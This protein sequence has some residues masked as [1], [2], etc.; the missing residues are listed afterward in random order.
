MLFRSDRGIVLAGLSAGAICWFHYG[1]SD[2]RKFSAD[3]DKLIKVTGLNFVDILLC[4]HYD[5][6][7]ARQRTLPR[8]V[9]S[10][11][12]VAVALDNCAALEIVDD[13][14]RIILSKPTAR[15][16]KAYW[17]GGEYTIQ[18]LPPT[19]TFLRL[20]SLMSK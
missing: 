5:T 18:A 19:D 2:S 14:Y 17:E 4:P 9:R 13:S 8:M 1:S 3:T 20:S 6:E 11:P 12:Y 15:A 10:A 7:P 16:Y